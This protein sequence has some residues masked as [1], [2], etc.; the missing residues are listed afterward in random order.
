M[1]EQSVCFAYLLKEQV[2][3]YLKFTPEI[4]FVLIFSKHLV[5]VKLSLSTRAVYL[6]PFPPTPD[7]FYSRADKMLS[8]TELCSQEKIQ[9]REK[10]VCRL[11]GRDAVHYTALEGS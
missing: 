9:T 2:K 7:V 4:Y 5:I 10:R 11:C 8:I 1:I 6:N 3:Y